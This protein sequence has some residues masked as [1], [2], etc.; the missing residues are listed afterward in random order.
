MV[1]PQP[2]LL[3]RAMCGSVAVQQQGSMSVSMTHITTRDHGDIPGTIWM[4]R[5]YAE[6]GLPFTGC[7]TQKSRSCTWLSSTMELALKSWVWMSHPRA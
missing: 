6:L 4:S 3:L 2:M 7:S 1:K 5:G